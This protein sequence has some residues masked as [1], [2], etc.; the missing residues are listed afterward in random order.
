MTGIKLN[1]A[2]VSLDEVVEIKSNLPPKL[3]IHIYGLAG[4]GKGTLTKNLA[5]L[6]NLPLLETSL[7]YRAITYIYHDLMLSLT[8]ENTDLVFKSLKATLKDQKIMVVYKEKMLSMGDLK[9]SYIDSHVPA[10]SAD[11][12]IR[13]KTDKFIS[14]LLFEVINGQCITDARGAYP[15]YLIEAQDIGYKVVKINLYAD[16][17][18]KVKR[19]YQEY[20]KNAKKTNPHF[21]ESSSEATEILTNC[22]HTLKERDEKDIKTHE[23]LNIGLVSDDSGIIDTTHLNVDEVIGTSLSY[24]RKKISE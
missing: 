10:Y 22:R 3:I 23:K 14:Y 11:K 18:E 7:V 8:P 9:N 4:V 16:F 24:L 21:D 12:Y 17:E 20:I 13:E 19:M 1:K 5:K 2:I 15:P 6:L